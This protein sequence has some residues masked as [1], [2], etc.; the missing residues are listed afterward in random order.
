MSAVRRFIVLLDIALLI[1]WI[2]LAIAVYDQLPQQIPTHFG[3]SGAADAWDSRTIANWLALPAIGVGATLL[4]LGMAQLSFN[5]PSMYNV[6]GKDALLALSP[7]QQR[8]FIEQLA[9]FMTFIGTSVLLLFMAIHYD[10]WRT[11]MGDQRG[12]S[13]VS[14]AA[15]ALCLGTAII[16]LPIW[17]LQFKRNVSAAHAQSRVSTQRAS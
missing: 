8:P 17:M 2:A 11:A 3:P 9:M 15:I 13:M 4:M 1:A 14:W 16:A 5:R 12:M 6:P 7:E 10:T